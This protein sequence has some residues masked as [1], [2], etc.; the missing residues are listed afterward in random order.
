M[1]RRLVAG[2]VAAL[3]VAGAAGA[4]GVLALSDGDEPEPEAAAAAE[5]S[6]SGSHARPRQEPYDQRYAAASPDEQLVADDLL[7]QT[8]ETV[9]ALPGP[10]TA[11]AAGYRAPRKPRGP[12][13][14]YLNAELVADSD[15]LDPAHPEGLL[16]I[17]GPDGLEPIGAVFVARSGLEAPADAGDLL[18]WHSHGA[19]CPGFF[20]TADEPCSNTRRMLHVWTAESAEYVPRKGGDPISVEL[21]DPFGAPFVASVA[22]VRD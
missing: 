16:F 2:G 12:I 19:K 9:A 10:A 22:R 1:E 11:E 14:H 3:L 13:H 7:A 8:R 4:A 21:V 17:D 15:V 5:A 20:A 18:A 6:G